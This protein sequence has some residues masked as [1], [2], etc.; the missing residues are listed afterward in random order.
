[1]LWMLFGIF[2]GSV[3][4]YLVIQYNRPPTEP[5][6]QVRF[7]QNPYYD[8]SPE[9]LLYPEGTTLE[10]LYPDRGFFAAIHSPDDIAIHPA[11]PT[12][13]DGSLKVRGYTFSAKGSQPDRETAERLVQTLCSISSYEPPGKLCMFQPAVLLRLTK[14]GTT[15]DMLFCFS[16]SQIQSSHDGGADMSAQGV[17]S[18][19]KSF[20]DALPNFKMLHE[21][22]RVRALKNSG[23]PVSDLNGDFR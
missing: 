6:H 16:C 21:F 13:A 1:M 15:Y 14:A 19:L 11:D 9:M 12:E 23:V 8:G 17:E 20:C 18:F 3:A 2:T 5:R 22:R 4:T 10:T 7:N